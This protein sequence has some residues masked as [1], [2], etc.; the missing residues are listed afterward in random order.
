MAPDGLSG[1]NAADDTVELLNRARSGDREAL[2]RL[3]D[4]HIPIL[5]R[6]ASGRLPRWARDAA[7]TS[8]VVQETV[9]ETLKHLDTFEPRGEGALQA[10]LRQ[11][12]I[13]RVRSALRRVSNRP[14]RVDLEPNIAD[15]GTSP[16]EAAIGRQMLDE[17]EAGLER[18]TTEERDAV[19]GRVELGLSYAELAAA[20]G[21]PSADAARMAVARA[22]VKLA[23]EMKR[24]P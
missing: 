15:D 22:L 2:D 14:A 9:V 13:N 10:Y 7:D 5:R 4:H 18:L 17:Y 6:W 20:L 3:F 12:V 8:D 11:A 16:L 21:R 24:T 19:V 1:A 23:K